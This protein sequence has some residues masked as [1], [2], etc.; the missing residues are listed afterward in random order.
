MFVQS[1][2]KGIPLL[3]VGEYYY[4]EKKKISLNSPKTRWRCSTNAG[5][6][7]NA[8]VYVINNEVICKKNEHN[9]P[10]PRRRDTNM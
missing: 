9:H 7:C 4:S 10:P 2:R 8:A 6:G 1:N 5:K 3:K